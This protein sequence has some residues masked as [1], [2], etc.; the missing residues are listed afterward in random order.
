MADGRT[1][2]LPDS[3]FALLRVLG[4]AAAILG[5]LLCGAVQAQQTGVFPYRWNDAP[6]ADAITPA[7]IREALMWTGHLDFVF[8]GELADAVR[9]ATKAWQKSKGHQPTDKLSDEQTSQLIQ[10]ALKEREAVGWS[11]LRDPAVGFADRRTDQARELRHAAH[12]RRHTLLLRRRHDHPVDRLPSR[13]S[14]LPDH[15]ARTILRM[16]AGAAF[17]AR[18]DNWFVALFRRGE[19]S[20]Y[21]KVNCHQAGVDQSRR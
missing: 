3:P 1:A 13:L 12:R 18:A 15:G 4:R 17:R 19:T 9:K 2:P 7:D 14:D 21:L 8:K 16:T 10:E 6:P 20:S 11:M 5:V